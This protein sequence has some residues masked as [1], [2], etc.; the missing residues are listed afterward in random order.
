MS[1]KLND[2]AAAV[3]VR[4]DAKA[5]FIEQHGLAAKQDG[6]PR[7]AGRIMGWFVI[8]GGPISLTELASELSVSRAS[9]STNARLLEGLGVLTRVAIPGERQD[10]Y[11]IA[12]S[13][14][15]RLLEGYVHRMQGNVANIDSLISGLGKGDQ[16]T[17][18]RARQM[19]RFYE[20]AITNTKSIIKSLS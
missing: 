16:G 17:R 11:Q 8:N 18:H 2:D 6:L 3:P 7:I 1:A 4:E 14:Y 10:F 15:A 9:I 5:N 19:K 12:D 20:A 13:P